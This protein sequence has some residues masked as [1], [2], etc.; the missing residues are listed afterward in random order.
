[1][2]RRKITFALEEARIYHNQYRPSLNFFLFLRS[3]LA[4][5]FSGSAAARHAIGFPK[6]N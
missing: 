5:I 1:M 6:K 4:V 3:L 2:K